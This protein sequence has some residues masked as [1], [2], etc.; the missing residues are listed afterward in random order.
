MRP[1]RRPLPRPFEGLVL[2]FLSQ[3]GERVGGAGLPALPLLAPG[4]EPR[5]TSGWVD[6]GLR[7]WPHGQ[8]QRP[9]GAIRLPGSRG[10]TDGGGTWAEEVGAPGSRQPP[11]CPHPVLPADAPG[12]HWTLRTST[13]ESNWETK[14]GH[15]GQILMDI[16]SQ[17]ARRAHKGAGEG[18]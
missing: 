3:T 17:A 8:T 18:L 16:V 12:T 13:R 15:C 2:V 10:Y 4:P 14:A 7:D 6:T 1:L 5:R 9:K 11:S